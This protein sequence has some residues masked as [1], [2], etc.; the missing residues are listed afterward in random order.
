MRKQAGLW[1]VGLAV[2]LLATAGLCAGPGHAQTGSTA[3]AWLGVY[4]QAL[5]PELREG[6]DYQGEGVLVN[7]VVAESPAERA[8]VRKG[9][10]IVSVNSRSV[11]MPEELAFVV[12]AARVGQEVSL[13]VVRD[14]V[15]RTLAAKLAAR[16][17]ERELEE[18][19]PEAPE[20]PEK[21][22]APE[23]PE[24]VRVRK[25]VRR[26]EPG[27][28]DFE[29][30]FD[31]EQLDPGMWMMRLGRGRLG[32]RV[33][34]LSPD[35]GGYFGVPDGKGALVLEV[36]KDTPAE[37]AGIKA[38]DVIVRVGTDAVA[39][40][41][42]LVSALRGEKG[43]VSLVTVR[44]GQK[45]TV[46]V[47]LEEGPRAV[48]IKPGEGAVVLPDREELR[49]QLRQLREEMRQLRLKLERLER[50]E[51]SKQ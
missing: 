12:A 21:P 10:V 3:K 51:E 48:R 36:V 38:G 41:D 4:T 13:V 1:G 43:R 16:P 46:E 20:A 33:E 7:R 28:G 50:T 37:R 45:R 18:L 31:L 47:V 17:A 35:L 23:K 34:S 32:V 8:G 30:F 49:E 44:K 39:D 11:S 5:S 42:D 40:A 26:V 2:A 19:S 27:S 29:N 25:F 24:D 6:L 15:K 14:G 9:D 22:G